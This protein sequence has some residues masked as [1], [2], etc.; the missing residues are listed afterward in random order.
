MQAAYDK[1]TIFRSA[2]ADTVW[3]APVGHT[4]AHSSQ[5]VHRL[6]SITGNPNEAGAPSASRSVRAA[7]LRLLMRIPSIWFSPVFYRSFPEYER[8]KL[9]LIT[10]KS[11]M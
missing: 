3:M 4:R 5:A 10:G 7:V 2:P 1:A 8:L 11:G 6:K 9:L